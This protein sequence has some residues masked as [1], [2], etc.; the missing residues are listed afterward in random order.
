[1]SYDTL[2]EKVRQAER[3]LEARERSVSAD[4]RQTRRSWRAIW[5]PGRIAAA[6]AIAGFAFGWSRAGRASVAGTGF[7]LLKLGTSLVTLA[8]SL[9]AKSAADEAGDAAATTRVAAHDARQAA[10]A[11]DCDPPA[12]ASDTPRPDRGER[13]R[14]DPSW[15][16]P[17]GAAEAATEVSERAGRR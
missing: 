15:A 2:L 13:R 8:S 16:S 1:M 7:G 3:A 5:T 4:W 14:P 12:L 10:E 17:P 11:G 9:Q 6:G